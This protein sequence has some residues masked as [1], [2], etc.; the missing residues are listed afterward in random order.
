MQDDNISYGLKIQI[1]TSG[2]AERTQQYNVR[3]I[4]PSTFKVTATRQN[5]GAIS[6][7][8][9]FIVRGVEI[10]K[11]SMPYVEKSG[12]WEEFE[13]HAFLSFKE[14]D[15][16]DV[17]TD[18]VKEQYKVDTKQMPLL[19]MKPF[20]EEN[21]KKEIPT[22]KLLPTIEDNDAN[23][24]VAFSFNA[25][26]IT[27]TMPVD[28]DIYPPY[29]LVDVASKRLGELIVGGLK[30]VDRTF[31]IIVKELDDNKSVE[32]RINF[33][34]VDCKTILSNEIF[35]QSEVDAADEIIRGNEALGKGNQR[36]SKNELN[37]SNTII[38]KSINCLTDLEYSAV[39]KGKKALIKFDESSK[40]EI[41]LKYILDSSLTSTMKIDFSF[42]VID[43]ILIG[44]AF[45]T[46]GSSGKTIGS[47]G[48]TIGS[49]GKTIG[50]SGKTIGSSA[51]TFT[52]FPVVI[53]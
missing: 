2:N 19:V 52:D 34:L 48:K 21:E 11:V 18:G 35:K 47:S 4:D 25:N 24:K 33:D 36:F 49:S 41:E 12:G 13:N 50:S 17:I 28:I 31:N 16:I 45:K 40:N 23:V 30:D 3:E 53:Q 26:V 1:D 32:V 9:I 46:I 20:V 6:L 51:L 37:A 29:L 42:L 39:K 44:A 8:V 22:L 5:S 27:D 38:N 43:S 7:E 15:I 10:K 14:E